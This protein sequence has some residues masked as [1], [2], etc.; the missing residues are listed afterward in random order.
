LRLPS[1]GAEILQWALTVAGAIAA[2]SFSG[3]WFLILV[4]EGPPAAATSYVSVDGG[5]SFHTYDVVFYSWL[6]ILLLIPR[7]R[8]RAPAIF[9]TLWAVN[10]ASF[11]LLYVLRYPSSLSLTLTNPGWP[12]YMV[13]IV[14]AGTGAAIFLR[15]QLHL[16]WQTLVF[17]AFLVI[18]LAFGLPL[19][20]PFYAPN[21]PMIPL[22]FWWEL[23]YQVT[24]VI[25]FLSTVRPGLESSKRPPPL[26]G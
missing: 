16:S 24:L 7:F 10:E 25:S 17:P 12:F 8:V 11:N 26:R 15:P 14:A 6:F 13:L 23:A 4:F 2:T 21:L 1:T 18:W 22:N 9:M 20:F 3:L 5:V 19:M